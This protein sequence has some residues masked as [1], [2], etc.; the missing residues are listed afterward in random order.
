MCREWDLFD[1][2]VPILIHLAV[3][4]VDDVGKRTLDGIFRAGCQL[5]GREL[6][7][8]RKVRLSSPALLP[9]L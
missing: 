8:V 5:V 4:Q 6:Q 1:M 7:A 9:M 2:A 3:G